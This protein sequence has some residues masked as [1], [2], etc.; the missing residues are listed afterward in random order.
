MK[1][2]T[3][4][5]LFGL[6]IV[7]AF[8]YVSTSVEVYS[9]NNRKPL[10]QPITIQAGKTRPRTTPTPKV[11]KTGSSKPIGS[12]RSNNRAVLRKTS[13]SALASANIPGYSGVLIES[14]N[15]AVV[16]DSYSHHAFNPASNVKVATS[17]AVLRTFGPN[18]RFRTGVWTDGSIDR[19]TST[20]IGNVYVS[21]RDPIFNY[22]H[23]VSI[24]NEL[25]RLGITRIDGNLIVTSNFAMNFSASSSRSGSLLLRTVNSVKRTSAAKK[26][27]SS[28]LANSRSMRLASPVPSVVFKGESYVQSLP[29][30]AQLLFT[31][32][33]APLREI[34][35]AT[36]SYSNNFLSERLGDM[37]G[38]AYRVANIVQRDTGVAPFEFSLA[39]CSGLGINRVTPRAQM[40]LLRV[41]K[42]F[43]KRNRM[44]FSDVMPVAGL[45]D[46][47]LRGRFNSG[48]QLGSVVG[49]TGTLRRT[50][51]GVSTLSGEITTRQGKFFFVIFNQRGN[52]GTFRSF[53]NSFVPLVQAQLGGAMPS[54][55]VPITMARRLAKSKVTYPSGSRFRVE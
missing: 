49:K 13:Y 15:G 14:E 24:A 5:K 38:G 39:S 53:Q 55:Y 1:S 29:S 16:L 52:V 46:G 9:Q 3:V 23:A 35:K 12:S 34:V 21:G 33:S 51:R 19:S 48:F 6:S 36:L 54:R 25:N 10:F 32:E 26:A 40:K 22:E 43:L 7:F 45:D 8:C 31:H 2:F 44:S 18:Y 47:T 42:K 41:Y 27:W 4:K 11:R 50:D 17:Y 37:L 28:Y 30:N 20:L